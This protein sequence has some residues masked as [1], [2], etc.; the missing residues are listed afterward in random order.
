MG[1]SHNFGGQGDG[2]AMSPQ[3]A[4]KLLRG[5]RW[6]GVVDRSLDL[7]CRRGGSMQGRQAYRER[8]TQAHKLG[9]RQRHPSSEGAL[10][11]YTALSGARRAYSLGGHSRIHERG[12]GHE[13]CQVPG[14][15]VAPAGSPARAQRRQLV[16][17]V[18]LREIPAGPG[19]RGTGS[20]EV[21]LR[22][23]DIIYYLNS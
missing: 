20:R 18:V 17:E 19:E 21:G 23:D 6:G 16:G 22:T 14:Q 7:Q 15:H 12:V 13:L 10:S 11:G 9:K 8:G 4:L 5:L 3:G 1:C 2:R